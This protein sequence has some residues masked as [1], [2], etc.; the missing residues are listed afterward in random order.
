M[1]DGFAV[2]RWRAAG[3]DPFCIALQWSEGVA[4][5]IIIFLFVGRQIL[6]RL[7]PGRSLMLAAAAG[8]LRWGA[9]T[10]AT[11]VGVISLV[12]PLHGHT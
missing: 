5:E 4:G 11:R 3:I 10:Q 1:H 9:L 6:D 7:G 2:I 8:V 12:E